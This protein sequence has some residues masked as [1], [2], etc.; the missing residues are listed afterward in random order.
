[1]KNYRRAET[2]KKQRRAR[3]VRAK[4]FGTAKRPRAA[5]YRSLKH[6]YV[7]LI[8]DERSATLVAASDLELKKGKSKLKGIEKAKAVGNLLAQK[9]AT[10]RIKSVVFDRKGCKYHGRVKALAEGMREG[11]LE[12]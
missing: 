4:V 1:M 9:A 7:Q 12:F 3:R 6:I 2:K 5:V 10:A 8:N 11:G